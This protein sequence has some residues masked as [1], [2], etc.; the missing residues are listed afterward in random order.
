M[1]ISEL[2]YLLEVKLSSFGDVEVFLSDWNEG[3]Q[4]PHPCSACEFNRTL[5]VIVLDAE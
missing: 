2:I 3:Y 4:P 1:K 5:N